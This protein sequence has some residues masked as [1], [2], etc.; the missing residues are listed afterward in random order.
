MKLSDVMSAMDL[1]V[2]AEMGLVIFLGVFVL[3][4]VQVLRGNSEGQWERARSLPLCDGQV[5]GPEGQGAE[6]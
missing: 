4:A 6:R 2:F 1:A 3:V 5:D